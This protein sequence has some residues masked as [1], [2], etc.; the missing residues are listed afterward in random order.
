MVIR[1][2][3]RTPPAPHLHDFRRFPEGRGNRYLL[4]TIAARRSVGRTMHLPGSRFPSA[5]CVAPPLFSIDIKSSNIVITPSLATSAAKSQFVKTLQQ[6]RAKRP[7][8][9]Q[10]RCSCIDNSLLFKRKYA[11]PCHASANCSA[12]T[13]AGPAYK[14][15]S[16]FR[17]HSRLPATPPR[18]TNDF[19]PL[20]I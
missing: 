20:P 17:I 1:G 9:A 8:F 15:K 10:K 18:A 2:T 4:A 16:A 7:V 6:I 14:Y 5:P 11:Q 12:T 3:R 13:A 19:P